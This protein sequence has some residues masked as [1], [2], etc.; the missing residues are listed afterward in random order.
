MTENNQEESVTIGQTLDDLEE[1]ADD[2]KAAIMAKGVTPSGG[3]N[4]YA[5]AISQIGGVS[6]GSRNIGEIV[7]STIPLED[8]GLHLLDG[9]LLQYGSYSTFIDYMEELYNI[10]DEIL[11]WRYTDGNSVEHV[12]YS[13]HLNSSY[14]TW[15]L[16]LDAV[17]YNRDG[18]LYTGT[19]FTLELVSGEYGSSWNIVCWDNNECDYDKEEVSG[20][21]G[22]EYIPIYVSVNKPDVFCTEVQWQTA[23][24]TY[25]VC[26]KFVYDSAN[27]TLRLP[28]YN[29]KIY[30]GGGEAPVA[31]NGIALGLTDGTNNA[32]LVQSS[33]SPYRLDNASGSYGVSI[34]TSLSGQ[35]VTNGVA[36][37]VTTDASKSG[38]IADLANITT[39]LDGY[40]Y[41]VI[42]SS[43]KTAIEVDIDEIATD[44]NGKADV[45][46]TNVNNIGKSKISGNAAP[47]DTYE[48][49]TLGASNSNY[50]APADGWFYLTSLASSASGYFRACVVETGATEVRYGSTTQQMCAI[51][52]VRKGQNLLLVY[53]AFDTSTT[54][55]RFVYAQGSEHEAS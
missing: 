33:S 20:E 43:V 53:N 34:G 52:H 31:G 28:K 26:G 35:S 15:G 8:A 55:F 29:S 7:T 46:L 37:G 50:E 40:Y 5:D 14:A 4:S 10:P 16:P 54:T 25:G 11:P 41:I 18:S 45:D 44:L 30:T 48:D 22:P 47:S 24:T 42:A 32:G 19:E 23:V 21:L 49:L 12:I 39:S 3:L 51:V 9:S 1:T 17:L 2:I 27:N 6:L 13:S 38:I 36:Y